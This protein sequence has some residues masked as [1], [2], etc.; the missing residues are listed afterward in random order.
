M[1]CIAE[2]GKLSVNQ[3]LDLLEAKL[4]SGEVLLF[5]F[6]EKSSEVIESQERI[7]EYFEDYC[8]D[9]IHYYNP[10]LQVDINQAVLCELIKN[11]EFWGETD[12]RRKKRKQKIYIIK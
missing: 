4:V 1:E 3:Q 11:V 10:R 12:D 5:Q 7:N 2:F 9:I 8:D 6:Y